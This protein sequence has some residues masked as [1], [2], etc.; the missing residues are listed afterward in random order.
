MDVNRYHRQVLL[1]QVGAAGQDRLFASRVL[2]VG[3]GALGCVI[4]EQL[5]RAGVGTLR[6]ADRDV[7]EWTNL[8][9]QVLFEESDARDGLPKAVA[10]RQRLARVNSEVTVEAI[11]TDVH[12]GNVESLAAERDVIVDGTDNVETRYLLNDVSI[13][14]GVPWVYGACVGTEGRVMPVRPG[15]TP[16]LRCVF[17][18]PPSGS[19]LPT[20]DTA[21][22][23]GPAAAV[24]GALQA[25][26]TIK[27]LVG[28]EGT[29][30]LLSLDV[31]TPRVRVTDAGPRD[32]HCPACGQRRFEFLDRPA[33]LSTT[34][35]GRQTVQVRP[36]RSNGR[37]DLAAAAHKF[38][39]AGAVTKTPYFI[40]CRLA[41]PPDVELTLFEDGR[42]LVKGLSNA[43][44]AR[45]LYARYV[46]N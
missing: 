19:D 5:V 12:S 46:G 31:W 44:S 20:C 34:L 30:N 29:S 43:D 36:E 23:L 26:A 28:A 42:L 6:I 7:V 9:R 39:A 24:V 33:V 10:A 15:V 38:A 21:G 25:A 35:C 22:V 14:H 40:R 11:V 4:A 16:C 41:D 8:Q 13:K 17:P 45:S 37:I 27:L 32:P 18:T 2:L 3:C 1:P